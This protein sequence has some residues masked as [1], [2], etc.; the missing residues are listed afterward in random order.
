MIY[1]SS[2]SITCSVSPE[3]A[4][5][6]AGRAEPAWELSWRPAPLLTREQA[7]AALALTELCSAGS[8]PDESAELLARQLD[9]TVAHVMAVLQQRRRDR[10]EGA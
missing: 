10:G 7:C 6:L 4:R 8:E 1:E 9:T 5:R 2:R 3:W